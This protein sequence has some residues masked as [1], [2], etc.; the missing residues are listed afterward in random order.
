M[1]VF[2]LAVITSIAAFVAFGAPAVGA[3]TTTLSANPKVV[4]IA[5]P[6]GDK[7]SYFVADARAAAAEAAK[8]TTNV[9]TILTPHATWAR[10]KTALQGASIV[11]N[12]GHGNGWPS[13]YAPWQPYT[14][15]GLGLNPVDTTSDNTTTQYHG[16]FYLAQDIRLAPNAI[17]LLNHLC[18]SAGNS[19]PGLPE[20]TVGVAHQR[21]DN[22]AAGWLRTGA[23]AVISEAYHGAVEEVRA[24]FTTRQT[25]D[26]LWRG[27]SP[28]SCPA[29]PR[30]RT[31][32]PAYTRMRRSPTIPARAC[33]RPAWPQG[34]RCASMREPERR[35]PGNRSLRSTGSTAAGRGSCPAPISRRATAPAR[36]SGRLTTAAARSHR[37]AMAARTP[38]A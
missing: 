28:S 16:E 25:I 37:T 12:M 3:A 6:V 4:I 33:P 21:L 14:K 24:L 22:F 20:P 27:M 30:H 2:A 34:P 32:E 29:Q 31:T 1:R 38:L 7:T 23:R 10:V 9:V 35:S 11:I 19:E 8:Y 36:T 17:V 26:Q 18:Y 13:P 5:G 15:D